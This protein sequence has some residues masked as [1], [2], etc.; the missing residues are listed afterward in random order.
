[1]MMYGNIENHGSRGFHQIN[2]DLT[3]EFLGNAGNRSSVDEGRSDGAEDE[4]TVV[5]P[6]Q[7]NGEDINFKS[8]DPTEY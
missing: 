8:L 6:D 4:T 7:G 2:S 5:E 1:M 3:N